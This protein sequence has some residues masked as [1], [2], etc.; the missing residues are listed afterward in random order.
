M[1]KQIL[2]NLLS[3]AIKFTSPKGTITVNAWIDPKEGYMLSV[4]DTG[5]GVAPGDIPKVMEPFGQID[6]VVNRSHS[7]TGLGLP[8]TKS[9]VELHGGS[10]ELQSTVDVGTTVTVRFPASRIV[11]LR[12]DKDVLGRRKKRSAG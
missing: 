1:V 11:T 2:L 3:N 10:F 5:L 9:L 12:P 8:L 7:G 4:T 6:S